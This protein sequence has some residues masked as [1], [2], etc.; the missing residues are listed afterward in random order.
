M[1]LHRHSTHLKRI[2]IKRIDILLNHH[3]IFVKI[4]LKKIDY[5]ANQQISKD[6]SHTESLF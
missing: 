1:N 5:K 4:D 3:K 2:S 6:W